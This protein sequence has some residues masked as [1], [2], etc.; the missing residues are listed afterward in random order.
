MNWV[1]ANARQ[2]AIYILVGVI[3]L[4]SELGSLY[5]LHGV[6][7]LPL[8]LSASG[9]FLV[10]FTVNFVLNKLLT[11]P[12]AGD[13]TP[14]QL[15][16]YVILVVFNALAS[17]A[18]VVVLDSWG[19]NYLVA[20]VIVTGFV[21]LWNFAVLKW[22]VFAERSAERSDGGE[23]DVERGATAEESP[24]EAPDGATHEAP[25]T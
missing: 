12:L 4:A 9:A 23:S 2:G 25:R 19:M 14:V 13:P 17:G 10:A 21:V 6:L 7:G 11:F 8:M 24:G 1:S 20:K 5:L 16:R 3:T 15:V 22:W 18:A